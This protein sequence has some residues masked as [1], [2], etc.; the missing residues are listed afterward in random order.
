M[1]TPR[2]AYHSDHAQNNVFGRINNTVAILKAEFSKHQQLF[3][4][5]VF[6]DLRL[7]CVQVSLVDQ[8]GSQLSLD[9]RSVRQRI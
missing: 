5:N 6:N 8:E 2:Q 7:G 4:C 9:D 1:T 3:T